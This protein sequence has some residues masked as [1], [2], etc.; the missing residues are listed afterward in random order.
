M[1]WLVALKWF[2][3]P[4]ASIYV[5]LFDMVSRK[6]NTFIYDNADKIVEHL[7]ISQYCIS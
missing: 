5:D 4:P 3:L 2:L 7:V 1:Q 6:A